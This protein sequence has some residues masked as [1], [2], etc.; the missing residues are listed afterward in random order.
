MWTVLQL[1]EPGRGE[2]G[3]CPQ[4]ELWFDK[5]AVCIPGEGHRP[6]QEATQEK[7]EQFTA[8]PAWE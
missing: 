4:E 6:R 7:K 1:Q 8:K 3:T 2:G 5:G